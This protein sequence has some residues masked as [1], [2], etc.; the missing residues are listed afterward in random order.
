MISNSL[1]T[2]AG[3]RY[4][5]IARGMLGLPQ[6]GKIANEILQKRFKM[7]RYHPV[8]LHQVYGLMFGDQ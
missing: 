3:Y 5:K 4:V 6:V 7:Y 1:S 8:N 2:M